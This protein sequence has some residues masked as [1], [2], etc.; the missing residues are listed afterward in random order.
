MA[1][2]EESNIPNTHKPVLEALFQEAGWPWSAQNS[3]VMMAFFQNVPDFSGIS[4]Y[5][6]Q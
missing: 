3:I 1:G 6:P 5:T 2:P 4:I